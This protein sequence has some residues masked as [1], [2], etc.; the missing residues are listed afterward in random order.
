[1]TVRELKNA[2]YPLSHISGNDADRLFMSCLPGVLLTIYSDLKITAR[3]SLFAEKI[4]PSFLLVRIVHRSGETRTL[5]LSGRAY[6]MRVS[7]KGRITVRDGS[8]VK[9][10]DFDSEDKRLCGFIKE[11]GCIL[12]S[13]EYF[14]SVSD[15]ALY[16][17]LYGESESD[18]P[19]A[20]RTKCLDFSKYDDF[21]AFISLPKT[22][23]GR[24]VAGAFYEG[25]KL[26]LPSDFEGYITVNYLKKP[27]TH[28][29]DDDEIIDIPKGYESLILPLLLCR[30]LTDEDKELSAD[31]LEIYKSGFSALKKALKDGYSEYVITDGW[32]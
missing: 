21:L 5:P 9:C 1:M 12:L 19:D 32:A 10:T 31:Y 16:S 2:T 15:F 13:G 23:D 14:F 30:M 7:G 18:I 4:R 26:F 24:A 27:R 17:D 22:P 6:S 20:G 8:S 25:N 29:F 3:K 11:G 28:N